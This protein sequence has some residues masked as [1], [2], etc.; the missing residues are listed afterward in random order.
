MSVTESRCVERC[1]AWGEQR[2]EDARGGARPGSDWQA[3]SWS[4]PRGNPPLLSHGRI[5]AV[6]WDG[7]G[8]GAVESLL[9]RLNW[10]VGSRGPWRARL[11]RVDPLEGLALVVHFGASHEQL[12]VYV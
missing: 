12:P 6:G 11:A 2:G 7:G 3:F 8:D 4:L 10:G 5:E 9:P 1:G